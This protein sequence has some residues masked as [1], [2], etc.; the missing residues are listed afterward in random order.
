[1]EQWS[2]RAMRIAFYFGELPLSFFISPQTKTVS[3]VAYPIIIQEQTKEILRL[4]GYSLQMLYL[5]IEEAVHGGKFLP[6]DKPGGKIPFP[7]RVCLSII[8]CRV[9]ERA[10]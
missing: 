10:I 1:M 9:S 5:L 7:G 3:W 8:H 6:S 2:V 4:F